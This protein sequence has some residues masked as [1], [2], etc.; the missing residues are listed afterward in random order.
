LAINNASI[1][2]EALLGEVFSSGVD[3]LANC[4][5]IYCSAHAD[6]LKTL[7]KLKKSPDF[8]K[9]VQTLESNEQCRSLKLIDFI[10]KP[11]QRI[12]KYPLLL[13][14]LL[15]NTPP[16]HL[17]FSPVEIAV[18]AI[19]DLVK[20]VNATAKEAENLNN[21]LRIEG[22]LLEAPKSMKLLVPG[23]KLIRE[24][25]WVKQSGKNVQVRAE[26]QHCNSFSP[27]PI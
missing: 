15:K 26:N 8:Q 9:L 14:E 17:D 6:A 20:K 13:R 27:P 12:C 1:P 24:G 22:C 11:V 10:V 23:R 21:L 18:S 4:Y 7:D 19:E 3:Q 25:M 16:E 2:S 5:S